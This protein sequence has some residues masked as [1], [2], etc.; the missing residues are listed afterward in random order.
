MIKLLQKKKKKSVNKP[1]VISAKKTK[2]RDNKPSKSDKKENEMDLFSKIPKEKNTIIPTMIKE[3]DKSDASIKGKYNNYM[4]EV[5]STVGLARYYRSYHAELK[6]DNTYFGMYNDLYLGNL[7]NADCDVAIHVSPADDAKTRFVLNRRIAGLESDLEMEKNTVKAKEIRD[8]LI[9]L[10][11]QE[12]R[13]RKNREQ[14]YSVN[15]QAI[16]NSQ[17]IDEINKYSSTMINRL[18]NQGT[19]FKADDTMQLPALLSLTPMDNNKQ[20]FKHAYRNMETSNLADMFPFG[21]GTISHTNGVLIGV[22][23][24]GKPVFYDDRHPQLINYNS[25]TLGESGSGKSMKTKILQARKAIH[26]TMTG[27][28]DYEVENR[29]WILELGFPYIEF[30]T[31]NDKYHLNIF[32][33]PRIVKT[34]DGSI[35]TDI[36]DAVK[37]V[38]AVVFKMLKITNEKG[39]PGTKKILIKEAIQKCYFNKRINYEPNSIYKDYNI[40]E[41]GVFTL[42]RQIKKMPQLI[43]LYEIM[44]TIPELKEESIIIKSFTKAGNIKSQAIFDCQTNV[45]LASSL[46]VGMSVEALDEIMKPLG[47]YIASTNMWSCYERLPKYI[48][49]DIIVDEAQNMMEEDEE[50]DWLENR[51]RIARRRNIGMH[52]IT[53]GFEVFLRKRQGLGILKNT[54]T[55]FLFRQSAM[56]IDAVEG[57]FNLPAGVKHRLLSFEQ[58]ECIFIAGNEMALI[59]TAPTSYELKLF[60]TNPNEDIEDVM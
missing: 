19:F 23:N 18:K 40:T 39:T 51:C 55:K 38:S 2:A 49:K 57:K 35:L 15:I 28:I 42:N 32:P 60:S 5:G 52:P 41:N 37:T 44:D 56:D 59:K 4:V 12:E 46:I 31:T 10:H 26:Q 7:G 36:D 11:A 22:D 21:F 33:I 16:V 30:S 17:N 54:A 9:E 3:V 58:G 1:V 14:L 53:Q 25:L 20:D 8:N 24:Y 34:R 50:A 13:L 48:K 29:D 45:D 27:I 47:L 43:E 6:G